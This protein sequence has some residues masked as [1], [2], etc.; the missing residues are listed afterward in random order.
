MG[1]NAVLVAFKDFPN[2]KTWV[3]Q[4]LLRRPDFLE[5]RNLGTLCKNGSLVHMD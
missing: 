2:N 1:I 3:V 4:N 5:R